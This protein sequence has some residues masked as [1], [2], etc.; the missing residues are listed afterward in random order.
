LVI[1]LWG[2]LAAPAAAQVMDIRPDGSTATYKGPVIASADGVRPLRA[3]SNATPQASTPVRAAITGAAIHHA[4]SPELIAA[5]AWQESRLRQSA[6]SPKGARGVMQLMPATAQGLRVDPGDL[7]ANVDGGAAYLAQMLD[8][9]DG[10]IIKTLAAYNAGPE[11]VTR[12]GGVPPYPETQAY[13]NAVLER[14]ADTNTDW[15]VQP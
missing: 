14:L 6:V 1:G 7:S 8:R 5:V 4:L 15:K 9:F 12:Y 13:V 3:G 11:A 2:V 10:D